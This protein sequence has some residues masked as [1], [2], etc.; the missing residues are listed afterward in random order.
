MGV[1]APAFAFYRVLFSGSVNA[2]AML[3]GQGRMFVDGEHFCL[4]DHYGVMALV[5]AH[6]SHAGCAAA[7]RC[8]RKQA[9]VRLRVQVAMEEQST[10]LEMEK[11]G[12]NCGPAQRA[13]LS[14]QQDADARK[15][16]RVAVQAR[17]KQRKELWSSAFGK[18]SLFAPHRDAM[19]A[20]VADAP[21]S[22]MDLVV[23]AYIGDRARASNHQ[24][25][26]GTLPLCGLRNL[27]DT[28]YVSCVS[29]VLMRM[30]PVWVWLTQH[31]VLCLDGAASCVACALHGTAGQ[32]GLPARPVL[33]ARRAIAHESFAQSSM[34]Y[35][36]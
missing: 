8:E 33:A 24:D 2:E 13:E 12:R 28:C 32:L 15:A 6:A 35:V 4:S 36:S 29:Q 23:E 7:E 5:D 20:A 11:I 30:S 26:V 19:Y 25:E 34:M 1:G 27:G 14:A 3:V 18:E 16:L 22:P 17:Q 10:V 31:A 21:L 9:L